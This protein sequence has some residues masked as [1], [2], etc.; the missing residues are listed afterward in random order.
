MTAVVS[1]RR[2]GLPQLQGQVLVLLFHDAN[3]THVIEPVNAAVRQALYDGET[4]LVASVVNLKAVPRLLR[5]MVTKI[6]EK[7]YHDATSHV[8]DHMDSA[9]YIVILLDWDGQ[10]TRKYGV[11]RQPTVVVVDQEGDVATHHAGDDLAGA[12][13]E[14]LPHLT[15]A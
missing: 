2:I 12:V 13:M 5:P 14:I 9:D 4:V 7:A 8:P 10:L 11:G 3:S 15:A 6:V 1:E